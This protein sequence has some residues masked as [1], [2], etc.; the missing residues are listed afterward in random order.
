MPT[1]DPLQLGIAQAA[2]LIETGEL[3]A[4]ALTRAC[5]ERIETRNAQVQAFVACDPGL[6]L[7]EAC[8]VDAGRRGGLLR[9]IPYAAKDV[10][11][12]RDYPTAHGSPI[13]EGNRP[14]RDAACVALSREQGAVLLGKVA[15]SEF[16]TQTPASVRNPLRLDHTPGGS[17][18]G[19]AAAVADGMAMAAWG[20]QTSGSITR[21]AIYCGVAGYK[22]SFGLVST[23]GVGT[24]SPLQDTV[25]VLARTVADAAA[26][27]FGIHGARPQ[28]LP[29]DA[30][31]R[32]GVC[33][34]SQWAWARPEAVEALEQAVAR[35]SAAGFRIRRLA[36]P[37]SFESLLDAQAQLVAYDARQALAHERLDAPQG[38]SARLWARMDGGLAL[39]LD[40]YLALHAR[41]AQARAQARAQAGA[42][43][44]GL[45]ALVYPATDGE[46]EQGLADSGSPRFGALWTLLHLPTLAFPVARGPAGLPLGLQ[47]IA[48]YGQDRKLLA[49]GERLSRHSGWA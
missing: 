4:E 20:T 11:D 48:P 30:A 17:S 16:A 41:A 45:D 21:P 44:D 36:L 39:S 34:S 26:F 9:G 6:A 32:L 5:L 46:A 10:I 29:E 22:P 12:T 8:A 14:S 42:L 49:M 23:A 15:T 19:S 31:P 2:R 28:A 24:L 3:S 35:A 38:L 25:G 37:A 1:Q 43:F 13:H 27:A 33:E 7:A 47:L 18:S 40:D